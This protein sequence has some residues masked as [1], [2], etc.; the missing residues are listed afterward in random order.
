MQLPYILVLEPWLEGIE[1]MEFKL[2]F[3]GH[4]P[5]EDKATVEV[6]HNIR[7]QLHPQLREVWQRHPSLG[8]FLR[9]QKKRRFEFQIWLCP[10]I[11]CVCQPIVGQ[12]LYL[13][14]G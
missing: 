9:N 2:L 11:W 8:G 6:K 13:Y 12:D 5:S 7:K 14:A 1:I 4:L 3:T 10:L